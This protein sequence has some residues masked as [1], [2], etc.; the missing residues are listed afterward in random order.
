MT[1]DMLF[2]TEQEQIARIDEADRTSKVQSAFSFT[3]QEIDDILR[4]G[5]NSDH[6]REHLADAL[7]KQKSVSEIAKLMGREFHGGFGIKGEHGDY[8]AWYA[9]DGIHIH[10][11]R[12]ARYSV[13]S[14]VIGWE[15]AAQRISE[16]MEEGSFATNV[17]RKSVV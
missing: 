4:Y 14:Q 1:L 16:L 13:G 2:P 11:G 15:D 10:K 9:E 12:E 5:S 17:D 8:A 7:M 6:A 3:Q